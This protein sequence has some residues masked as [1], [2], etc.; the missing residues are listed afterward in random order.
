[1]ML[2]KLLDYYYQ[3]LTAPLDHSGK[4]TNKPK[5]TQFENRI[6]GW[7]LLNNHKDLW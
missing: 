7:K 4:Y 3:A 2:D 6:S 1:M 5:E